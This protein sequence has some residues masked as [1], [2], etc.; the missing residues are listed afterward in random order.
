M[1]SSLSSAAERLA[2]AK[3]WTGGCG[4]GATAGAMR[5]CVALYWVC[6]G[7]GVGTEGELTQPQTM[8]KPMN[9]TR[10]VRTT[11]LDAVLVDKIVDKIVITTS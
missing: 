5:G 10:A 6:A 7:V 9:A 8:A 4:A 2:S 1:A 11:L 3:D